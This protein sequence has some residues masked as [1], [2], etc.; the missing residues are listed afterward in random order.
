MPLP[1]TFSQ[2]KPVRRVVADQLRAA[3]QHGQLKPGEWLRQE[4][5]AQELGVSQMPV[6]EALKELAAEGLIE[7]LPFRGVRVI[8]YS[9]DD[10]EDLYAQRSFL[11]ARAAFNAARRMTPAEISTLEDLQAQMK[12]RLGPK[13]IAE[14]RELNRQF[15]EVISTASHRPYLIRA[16]D[17]MWAIF[18]T[19]LLSNFADTMG[20]PLPNREQRDPNEHD[21]IIAALAKRDS[22]RAERLVRQH[23]E[24]AGKQ[25]I[26]AIKGRQKAKKW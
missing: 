2:H 11:E 18:P 26:A 15:H 22:D 21:A 12:K 14:Y 9:A 8:E 16:L 7:Y 13:H 20:Q 4:R 25:L 19:M 5:L 23:I 6:R 10:V 1:P 17:Q 3:I 24:S